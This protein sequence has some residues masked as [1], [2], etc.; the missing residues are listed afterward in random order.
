MYGVLVAG[1]SL[2]RSEKEKINI[3]YELEKTLNAS[4]SIAIQPENRA[5]RAAKGIEEFIIYDFE[6]RAAAAQ[7][8]S[9]NNATENVKNRTIPSSISSMLSDD[10]ALIARPLGVCSNSN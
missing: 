8:E 9:E 4:K 7:C 1:E 5:V 6:A 3:F 2:R 10:M